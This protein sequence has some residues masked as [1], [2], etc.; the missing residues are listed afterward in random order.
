MQFIPQSRIVQCKHAVLGKALP[1]DV[2]RIVTFE[3]GQ[4]TLI[5]AAFNTFL[6]GCKS[7]DVVGKFRDMYAANRLVQCLSV[8]DDL[9]ED[10]SEVLPTVFENAGNFETRW[11]IKELDITQVKKIEV[12]PTVNLSFDP[13]SA[14]AARLMRQSL[15]EFIREIVDAQRKAIRTVLARALKEGMSP[16]EASRLFRD[17]IGLTQRQMGA[18]SNYRSLLQSGSSEA[19]DRT[20]RDRR[21]DSSVSRAIDRGVQLSTSQIDRMVGRY[22]ERMLSMRAETIARTEML[23]TTNVARHQAMMQTATKVDL[24]MGR[25]R[26]TWRTNVDGRER[27]THFFLNK[28]ERGAEEH[29]VSVSGAKLMYPGDRSAPAAETIQ[30]RCTTLTKILPPGQSTAL[31]RP[32]VVTP[33]PAP[34]PIYTSLKTSYDTDYAD[35]FVTFADND[36]ARGAFNQLN[37]QVADVLKNVEAAQIAEADK[38]LSAA[39]KTAEALELA[40]LKAAKKYTEVVRQAAKNRGITSTSTKTIAGEDVV[41][42]AKYEYGVP[43]TV[44]KPP[45]G[46]GKNPEDFISNLK[47]MEMRELLDDLYKEG[48]TAK[49]TLA[50]MDTLKH[51]TSGYGYEII[52]KQVVKRLRY[53]DAP[54]LGYAD[55]MRSADRMIAE[56]DSAFAKAVL[57]ED[58]IVYRGM[59]GSRWKRTFA[60]LQIGQTVL[61]D[62]AV[63]S[64]SMSR[65]F[66]ANWIHG[67]G[68]V[69]EILLPKGSR[70]IS[71][72]KLT[73]NKTE[74]EILL[75]RGSKFIVREIKANAVVLELLP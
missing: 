27:Q 34:P 1:P 25:I 35:G 64:T 61:I 36:A 17:Q 68:F 30:C 32:I 9:V 37:S 72:E 58:V 18:V 42:A 63:L 49:L 11:L 4:E 44:T 33:K 74:F 39:L 65:S 66:A 75:D 13:G 26:R 8:T 43:T 29:F 20:L 56:L 67:S 5:R 47:T 73:S 45:K 53:G 62:Q 21:F 31:Q 16:I 51:Y 46:T 69:V 60:S 54:F 55:T 6:E 28:Q 2:R 12:S 57:A 14:D 71:M 40:E 52:N 22:Q 70:A 48:F 50:E 41:Q 7:D 38:I 3:T 23:S 19:L 15:L 24:E 10:F 59:K